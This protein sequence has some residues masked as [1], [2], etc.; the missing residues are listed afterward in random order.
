MH[1]TNFIFAEL[2]SLS[3]HSILI[4]HQSIFQEKES[5]QLNPFQLLEINS[6]VN[7]TLKNS[8]FENE[9]L[10]NKFPNLVTIYSF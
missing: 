1:L 7:E 2:L 10:M 4:N 6:L 8:I 5:L 9:I 3:L